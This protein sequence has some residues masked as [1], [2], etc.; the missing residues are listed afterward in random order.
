MEKPVTLQVPLVDELGDTDK[1]GQAKLTDDGLLLAG[2][3]LPTV[4]ISW[5]ELRRLL[6]HPYVQERLEQA[7]A[8]DVM[9]G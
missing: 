9:G 5:A 4:G 3:F 1:L 6:N 7:W 2:Y 8:E